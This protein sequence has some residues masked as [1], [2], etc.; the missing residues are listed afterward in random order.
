MSQELKESKDTWRGKVRGMTEGEI[1]AFLEEPVNATLAC[2]K[3]D[4][5]P[6]VAI[7]WQEWRDGA[8]WVI[9]RQ[10]SRWAEYLKADPRVSLVIEKPST[11]QKVHVPDGRAEL[12]EEPN[13][14]GKW[15]EIATRMSYRYLGENGPKYLEPTLNQPRWLFKIA[16]RTV[17]SWQGVGWARRY[18]VEGT[19]GPSYE[20]AFGLA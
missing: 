2:L 14:G 10:R 3:P 20:E 15:T 5:S 16:P 7:C 1:D 19:G 6:Y 17:K 12:V 8:F 4:G 11:M 13:V 18:W 9:P